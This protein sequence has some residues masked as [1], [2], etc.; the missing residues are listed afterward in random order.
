MAAL[1]MA[2]H[3]QEHFFFERPLSNFLWPSGGGVSILVWIFIVFGCIFISLGSGEIFLRNGSL[4]IYTMK[5]ELS[6]P[7]YIG[8]SLHEGRSCDSF[9]AMYLLLFCG[10]LSY[11]FIKTAF[12]FN[13]KKRLFPSAVMEGVLRGQGWHPPELKQLESEKIRND[14]MCRLKENQMTI[15]RERN[16]DNLRWEKYN[17]YN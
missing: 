13:G 1:A 9:M 16:L 8:E 10:I 6:F 7:S 2:W 5:A 12:A 15:W 14:F 4:M 11:R 3:L 17:T